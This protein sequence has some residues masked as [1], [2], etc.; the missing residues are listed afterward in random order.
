[1][2]CE[3]HKKES[4]ILGMLGMGG[5]AGSNLVGGVG[6]ISAS[7]G[8]KTTS[9]DYTIH[10]FNSPDTFQ[11]DSFFHIDGVGHSG[12]ESTDMHRVISKTVRTPSDKSIWGTHQKTP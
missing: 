6:P 12:T 5:G 8:T 2:F 9:G 3:K 10:T 4:P 1:M 11:V 7:G